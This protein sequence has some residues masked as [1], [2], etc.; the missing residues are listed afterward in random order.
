MFETRKLYYDDP[1]AM[2]TEAKILEMRASGTNTDIILDRTVCY[3]EGGGQPCDLGR[4]GGVSV[5]NALEEGPAIV[6]TVEGHPPFSPGDRVLMTIDAARRSDH[7]QQHSGQHL[8][9]AILER[10]Y[11]VHTVGFHLGAAYCTIDATCEGMDGEMIADIEAVAEGF[12]VEDHP[13]V[14]HVCPP[15]DP[16]SFPLRKKPPAGEMLIRVVEIGGY[17]WVACC[18]THVSS[19]AALR[20]LKILSTEKYKGKTRIYFVAGD[21]G[22]RLL[23][24]HQA[25]LKDI[26]AGLG[27]A[28]EEAASRVSSLLRR[29]EALETDK[30][31]LMRERANLEIELALSGRTAASISASGV[32]EAAYL[33]PLRFSYTDRGADAAFE[34]AKAGAACGVA[35]VA[36]SVP[37][38]TVCAMAPASKQV[39]AAAQGGTQSAA[40]GAAAPPIALGAALKPLLHRFA[41]K[42]GGGTNNFRAVFE[43]VE[44]AEA[45]ASEAARLLG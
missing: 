35:V 31:A 10:N 3:P 9:S 40:D 20:V 36:V 11:G 33:R 18:G 12:I 5:L 4:L 7:S 6:H 32:T 19:A 25:I 17:D 22:I 30:A 28:A 37:D 26:A 16:E 34:T 21:R 2:A 42:G 13:F 41:G 15:E 24:N 45:F 29:N 14:I 43:T 23:K 38:R 27:T 44:G 39:G 1:S 8:L